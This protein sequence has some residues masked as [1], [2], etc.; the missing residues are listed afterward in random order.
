MAFTPSQ[1]LSIT[2]QL[3]TMIV[4]LA[5]VPFDMIGGLEPETFTLG[6]TVE[7]SKLFKGRGKFHSHGCYPIGPYRSTKEYILACYDRESTTTPMPPKT[8]STRTLSQTSP[9]KISF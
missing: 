8:L 6:P 3:A 2:N 7:G 1:K 9:F 5:E 4:D